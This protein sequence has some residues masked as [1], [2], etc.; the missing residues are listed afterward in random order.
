MHK[1]CLG[2]DIK[3]GSKILWISHKSN[4]GFDSGV[5]IV[6][7]ESDKRIRVQNEETGR[8]STVDPRTV[9]VVDRILPKDEIRNDLLDEIDMCERRL[10]TF[11]NLVNAGRA[12]GGAREFFRQIDAQFCSMREAGKMGEFQMDI[13]AEGALSEH[14]RIDT[15]GGNC[16]VQ[17]EGEILGKPFYFRARG[18][19]WSFS[20]GSDP[21]GDPEWLH[22]EDYGSDPFAAGWMTEDEALS[23]IKKASDIYIQS[24]KPYEEDLSF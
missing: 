6:V 16:P 23:F 13:Q 14:V 1:D 12:Q 7:S 3:I 22:E 18:S 5:M 4:A 24:M 10:K 8:C 21:V 15:L 2:Q 11:C 9:V 20:V 17:S 19:S